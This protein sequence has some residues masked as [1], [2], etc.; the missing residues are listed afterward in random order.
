MVQVLLNYR[1]NRIKGS[2]GSC[3]SIRTPAPLHLPQVFAAACETNWWVGCLK[4]PRFVQ[5]WPSCW[6]VNQGKCDAFP[7]PHHGTVSLETDEN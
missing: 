3:R 5:P 2:L 4:A 6:C 1:H 7:L